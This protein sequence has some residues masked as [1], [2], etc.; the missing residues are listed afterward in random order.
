[1]DRD[2]HSDA[3]QMETIVAHWTEYTLFFVLRRREQTTGALKVNEIENDAVR[4]VGD[5]PTLH[6]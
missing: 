2:E 4:E 3:E 5:H 6:V 1:M